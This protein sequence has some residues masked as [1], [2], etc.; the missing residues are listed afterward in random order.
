M[1]IDKANKRKA[2]RTSI[3]RRSPS[4]QRRVN[5]AWRTRVITVVKDD[6]LAEVCEFLAAVL[7]P[8][9]TRQSI[10]TGRIE[11]LDTSQTKLQALSDHLKNE[12][13]R[14]SGYVWFQDGDPTY[15]VNSDDR[16]QRTIELHNQEKRSIELQW[17]TGNPG[18]E[19][20]ANEISATL[21]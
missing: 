12:V 18:E 5:V 16:L 11:R 1:Q 19:E 4:K 2:Q 10:M 3:N 9:A 8:A 7:S 13:G 6:T 21:D 14:T 20:Q 17:A 15:V